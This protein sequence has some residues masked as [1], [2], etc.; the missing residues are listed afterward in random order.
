MGP[1]DEVLVVL[2]GRATSERIVGW[3]RRLCG[4]S[5]ARVRLLVVRSPEQTVCVGA[6][7]VAFGSQ[8]EDAIRLEALA[9]L[10]GV[11]G[12]LEES[13]IATTSE[14]RFGAAIDAVLGAARDSGATLLALA[15]P[16]QADASGSMGRLARGLLDRAPIPVLVARLRHQRA[17]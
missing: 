10:R 12:P 13:G 8:L 9:Y 16:V 2:D 15:T 4:R 7:P 6:R 1:F 3:V 11:A 5:G 17:A 14:V